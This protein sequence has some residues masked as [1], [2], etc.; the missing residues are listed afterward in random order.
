MNKMK[1]LA[2]AIAAVGAISASSL[3]LADGGPAV[4][5]RIAELE[6]QLAELKA[7]VSSNQQAVSTRKQK[8]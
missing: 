6:R 5:D 7:M 8:H 1:P 3:T 4:D 2:A